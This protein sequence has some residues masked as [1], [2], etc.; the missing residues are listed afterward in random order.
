MRR[1]LYLILYLLFASIP[2]MAKTKSDPIKP[3]WVTHALPESKSET[4]I[5]E[6][7][8]VEG[9]SLEDARR[10]ALSDLSLRLEKEHNLHMNLKGNGTSEICRVIDEYWVCSKGKYKLHVLYTIPKYILPGYTGKLGNS[11][12]D[13][14]S[15]TTHYGAA[16]LMSIVPGVGQIYKGSPGKGVLFITS[17][18]ASV[19]GIILCEST[20]SSYA[21]KA[22]EQPKFMKQYT[23]RARN[24][25]TGRS[26]A[27]GAAGA[28]FAWNLIDALVAKGGKRVVVKQNK[29]QLSFSPMANPNGVGLGMMVKF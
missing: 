6:R 17:E 9:T 23:E 4:Y 27:I 28:F 10:E 16:G 18:I 12:N 22:I 2:V 1:L 3:R 25:E 8:Y 24:W 5:F 15:V 14:I 7:V 13:N 29:T 26:I 19:A 11:Y 21:R 20:R